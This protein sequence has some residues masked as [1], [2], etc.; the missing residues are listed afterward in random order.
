MFSFKNF[1]LYEE[2][3]ANLK[4]AV[5]TFTP[6]TKKRQFAVDPLKV[7]DMRILAY[8]GTKVLTFIC[9]VL[10]DSGKEYKVTMSFQGI[11]YV[12]KKTAGSVTFKAS[13]KKDYSIMPIVSDKHDIRLR[14]QCKDF[15]FRFGWYTHRDKAIYGPRPTPYKR[16]TDY[17]PSVNPN[18][19]SGFCKHVIKAFDAIND[20]GFMK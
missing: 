6:K 4:K 16:K 12:D 1:L 2:T 15:Y 19:V 3:Y 11:E 9:I 8:P 17:W 20:S 14:C 7:I 18:K 10:S 13:D 5:L